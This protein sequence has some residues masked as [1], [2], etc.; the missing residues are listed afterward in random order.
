MELDLHR[1]PMIVLGLS[2]TIPPHLF[3]LL[4]LA[5]VRTY[6]RIIECKRHDFFFG[7]HNLPGRSNLVDARWYFLASSYD[8]L[9]SQCWVLEEFG[10]WLHGWVPNCCRVQ[11][12]CL[13]RWAESAGGDTK[14][15]VHYWIRTRRPAAPARAKGYSLP[16]GTTGQ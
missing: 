5:F 6:P 12:R 10:A 3:L 2:S 7:K 14:R 16:S 1:V 8:L 4:R 11:F 15:F 13:C 9:P